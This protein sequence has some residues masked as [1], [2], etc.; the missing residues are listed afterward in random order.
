MKTD[1]ENNEQNRELKKDQS[2]VQSKTQKKEP[3]KEKKNDG[4]ERPSV[5]KNF[6]GKEI[7]ITLRNSNGIK[8]RLE[9]IVQY[10]LVI[11]TPRGPIIVMKHAIDYIELAGEK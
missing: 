7:T 6:I 2:K 5:I 8:G 10:E 4:R 9:T 3:M 11:T 1:T